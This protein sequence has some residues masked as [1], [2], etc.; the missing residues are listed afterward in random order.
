MY[1]N[2][3]ITNLSLG[4]I[5]IFLEIRSFAD[6]IKKLGLEFNF[7]GDN[8]SSQFGIVISFF[9]FEIGAYIVRSPA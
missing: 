6:D 3:R 2:A 1:N 5:D 7:E 4:F 9:N 8:N